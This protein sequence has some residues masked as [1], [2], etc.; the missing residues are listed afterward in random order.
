[1][2]RQIDEWATQVR[3]KAETYQRLNT[4]MDSITG[5]GE[6]AG[7]DVRVTVNRAG[8][9]TALELPEQL[10]GM[11]GPTLSGEIMRAI[12]RA[13]ATL[14]DKVV[15]LMRE[16]VPEDTASIATTADAYARQFPDVDGESDTPATPT[17]KPP[18]TT[19]DLDS[20]DANAFRTVFDNPDQF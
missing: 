17:P 18:T 10:S 4:E 11:R 19:D 12:Q 16:R 20:F 13:Q 1:M 9:V 2:E 15:G 6:A 14:G 7:G 5:T 8:V 3:A